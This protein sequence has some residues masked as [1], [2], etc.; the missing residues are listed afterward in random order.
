MIF[1]FRN[2]FISSVSEVVLWGFASI[3]VELDRVVVVGVFEG[4][5]VLLGCLIVDSEGLDR[6]VEVVKV[7]LLFDVDIRVEEVIPVVVEIVV[8]V[9]ILLLVD[10]V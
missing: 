9:D 8:T 1:L 7:E 3:L 2:G 10:I 5:V 6:L 4:G